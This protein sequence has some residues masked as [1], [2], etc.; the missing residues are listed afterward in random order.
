MH[1]AVE[2]KAVNTCANHPVLVLNTYQKTTSL[3]EL[4]QKLC[5]LYTSSL[6]FKIKMCGIK[7][8]GCHFVLCTVTSFST[9]Q[10]KFGP[11]RGEEH[12]ILTNRVS[13]LYLHYRN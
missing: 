8:P 4:N 11:H 1:E 13:F 3:G 2:K 6:F 12:S 9:G 7:F 10:P 5:V